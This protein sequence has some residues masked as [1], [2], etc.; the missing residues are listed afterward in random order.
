MWSP[1]QQQK[2]NAI[3]GWTAG[4]WLENQDWHLAKVGAGGAKRR[5][6]DVGAAVTGRPAQATALSQIIARA[7]SWYMAFLTLWVQTTLN[8]VLWMGL[9]HA[10]LPEIHRLPKHDASDFICFI[11]LTPLCS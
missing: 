2:R 1:A 6:P 8:L 11:V 9:V 7:G 4:V 5:P 3:E 10:N